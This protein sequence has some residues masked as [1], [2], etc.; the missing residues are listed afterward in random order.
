MDWKL[1][2]NYGSV[3]ANATCAD[4][5]T[6]KLTDAKLNVPVVTLSTEDK[7]RLSKL[8]SGGFKGSVYWNKYKLL[9]NKIVEI[10]RA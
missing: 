6:F 9:D 1:Y 4:G 2:V 10:S 3:G 7:A 8:L 5:G